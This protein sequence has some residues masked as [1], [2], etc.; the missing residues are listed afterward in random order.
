MNKVKIV[1]IKIHNRKW[2]VRFIDPSDMRESDVGTCWSLKRVIDIDGSLDCEEAKIILTHELAHAFLTSC[3]DL[4]QESY[5]EEK[6]CDF[7]AWNIDEIMAIRDK[8]IK[9]VFN[10]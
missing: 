10:Q 7:V 4:H 9:V 5:N 2:E 6:V 8:V 1:P 3:G